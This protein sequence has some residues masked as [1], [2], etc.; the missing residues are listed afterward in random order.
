[1]QYDNLTLIEA[2]GKN[3]RV[4]F[5]YQSIEG[6]RDKKPSDICVNGKLTF[7]YH[8]FPNVVIST[9]PGC[10]QIVVLEPID[11]S[12]T[13][14]YTYLV[15]NIVESETEL[16]DAVFEGQ[17]FASIGASEDQE[18]VISAQQGLLSGAN[19][20]LEFGLFESAIVRLHTHLAKELLVSST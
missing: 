1:V 12:T 3:S 4:S 19:E 10:M 13:E 15:S 9:F 17:K 6:L 14:H 5:P 16:I 20:F 7:V 2:F 8:L 18:I 11:E